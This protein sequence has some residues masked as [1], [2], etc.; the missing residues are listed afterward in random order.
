[1]SFVDGKNFYEI[2]GIER[3]ASTEEIK[4]AYKEIAR[5]YHP[6]S[7]FYADLVDQNL[8]NSHLQIFQEITAAYNTLANKSK[9][10][11]YDKLLAPELRGWSEEVDEDQELLEALEKI[12]VDPES[13]GIAAKPR[14][15]RKNSEAFGVFGTQIQAG[16]SEAS[17]GS[18]QAQYGVSGFRHGDE[19]FPK[20]KRP[21]LTGMIR[22][23]IVEESQKIRPADGGIRSRETAHEDPDTRIKILLMIFVGTGSVC[24]GMSIVAFLMLR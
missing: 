5:V 12:G 18:I 17:L 2:L 15:K 20:P 23:S 7:N 19:A 14:R 4:A 24:F 13:V 6:D 16:S 3:D 9:R 11:E 8:T 1:M 21:T 10:V 22:P